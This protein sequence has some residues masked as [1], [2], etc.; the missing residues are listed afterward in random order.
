MEVPS[1]CVESVLLIRESLTSELGKLA[2]ASGI[3]GSLRAMR[4]ALRKFLTTV[5]ADDRTSIIYGAQRGH[6]ASWIFNG[7]VG[8]LH[9]VFGIHIALLAS[10]HGLDVADELATIIP[11][12]AEDDRRASEPA[13][14]KTYA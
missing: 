1:H 10:K 14:V 5:G 9:G 7:A 2:A 4:A 8:E 13:H 3:C 6:D 11:S 12:V